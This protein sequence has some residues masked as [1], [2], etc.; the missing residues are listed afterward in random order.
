[1]N[2]FDRHRPDHVHLGARASRRAIPA[3][4]LAGALLSLPLC[5]APAQIAV[6]GNTVEE[7][8]AAPGESYDGTILIRNLSNQSQPVRIYQTDYTFSSDGTSHFDSTGSIKRSNAKWIAVSTTALVVPAGSDVPVA[9]AVKVPPADTMRGTYW[10]V[11]MVE[12]ATDAPPSVNAT[13]QVGLG[14]VV[15]YAVQVATHIESSG[16][17]KINFTNQHVETERDS[18]Q[19]LKLA[20]ENVGE[21]AYRPLVWVEV[22]D[23]K[24]TLRASAKQ[25]R[26]LIYPGSSAKQKFSLGALEAGNYKAIVFADVGSD[27][28]VAAQYKLRF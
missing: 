25:Q 13:S 26:G 1:M 9:Y 19:S 27:E 12:G 17:R 15:R 20:I 8:T 21:R 28:V 6:V 3:L 16:S 7:H 4:A 5:P 14:V 10:S 24:G 11:V 23:D 18:T 22:Y 2:L